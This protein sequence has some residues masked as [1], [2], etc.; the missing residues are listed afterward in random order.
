MDMILKIKKMHR[1]HFGTMKGEP[2]LEAMIWNLK[3]KRLAPWEKSILND[4][5]KSQK[6]KKKASNSLKRGAISSKARKIVNQRDH[7]QCV[8]CGSTLNPELA[9]LTS[10]G[11]GGKGNPRNLATLCRKHHKIL[12]NPLGEK[13]I[14]ERTK[15]KTFISLWREGAN[16][17]MNWYEE[18][19]GAYESH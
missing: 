3:F 19:N 8:F 14:I 6:P 15:L 10:R 7:Q 17:W 9:H 18:K 1:K 5:K 13:E 12:D 16:S 11:A 2:S 4:Y